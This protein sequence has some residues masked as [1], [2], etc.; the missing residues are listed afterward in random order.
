[1][2][3][4]R[5]LAADLTDFAEKTNAIRRC[6]LHRAYYSRGEVAAIAY[7]FF[8]IGQ[9]EASREAF[10]KLIWAAVVRCPECAQEA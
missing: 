8:V 10:Q 5:I 4:L 9:N 1:M 7:V 2:L 6:P 3:T